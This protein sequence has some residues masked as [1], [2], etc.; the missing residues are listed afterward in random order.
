VSFLV[1]RDAAIEDALAFDADYEAQGFHLLTAPS[2]AL[3]DRRLSEAPAPYGSD[4]E[5]AA[6]L[7]SVTEI[8][9][10]SGRSTNTVQS[11]R[12]RHSDFPVPVASLATGPVWTWP[13]VARW[14]DARH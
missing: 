10:R 6:Q 5:G 8:A 9:A 1:M 13:A 2:S 14:I 4:F 3:T 12:R 11:W 7:V